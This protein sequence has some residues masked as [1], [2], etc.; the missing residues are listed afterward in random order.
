MSWKEEDN[1]LK[2]DFEFDDFVQAFSFLTKVALEAE[3]AQHHPEIFNVYNQ[4]TITLSTH[5]EGNKVTQKDRDLAAA[6]DKLV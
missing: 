6:I 3:K 5:D 2:R 4:V 1:K